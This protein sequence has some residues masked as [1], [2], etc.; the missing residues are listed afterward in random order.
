MG[1]WCVC[2]R[3]QLVCSGV[4]VCMGGARV[5][6]SVYAWERVCIRVGQVRVCA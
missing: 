3:I 6:A 1:V 2:L 4:Y 5:F